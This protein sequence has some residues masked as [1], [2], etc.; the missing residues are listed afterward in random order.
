MPLNLEPLLFDLRVARIEQA[1]RLRHPRLPMEV[2]F[3]TYYQDPEPVTLDDG[4]ERLVP[5]QAVFSLVVRNPRHPEF[6]KMVTG[7]VPYASWRQEDRDAR[8]DS[9]VRL[10]P[11]YAIFERLVPDMVRWYEN[12]LALV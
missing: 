12:T 7:R 1:I 9:E 10:D 11:A 4:A 6:D 3:V 8:H 5:A 2:A